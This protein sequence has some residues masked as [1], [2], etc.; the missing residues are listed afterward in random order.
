MIDSLSGVAFWLND[1][2][3]YVADSSSGAA[4]L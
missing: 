1:H 4:G 2:H 3:G